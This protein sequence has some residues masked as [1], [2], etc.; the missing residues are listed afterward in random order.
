MVRFLR[1]GLDPE[2]RLGDLQAQPLAGLTGDDRSTSS[3]E[4]PSSVTHQRRAG[5]DVG[6]LTTASTG[7]ATTSAGNH[8]PI[9][10]PE[11]AAPE[12][13]IGD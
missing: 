7:G 8:D 4:P 12:G 1:G 5:V 11:P 6:S 2:L 3:V 13:E 10:S 9:F